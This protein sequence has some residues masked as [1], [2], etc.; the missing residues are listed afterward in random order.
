[1]KTKDYPMEPEVQKLRLE[2]VQGPGIYDYSRLKTISTSKDKVEIGCLKCGTW[3]LVRWSSLMVGHGCQKCKNIEKGLR[4]RLP[5]EEI[6]KRIED[7][8]PGV[9]NLNS[10]ERKDSLL[11]LECKKHGGGWYPI[12]S[13]L[14]GHNGC[15]GCTGGKKIKST[16][17]EF[18]QKSKNK[19]GEQFD[20]S[21]VH[22]INNKIPVNLI[23][24]THNHFFSINPLE[25]LQRN[26]GGCTFCAVNRGLTNEEF[27]QRSK[28]RFPGQLDYSKTKYLNYSDK[29][30]M[31][32]LKEGHGDFE[33]IPRNHLNNKKGG[34]G[35]KI[36]GI[37]NR[38]KKKTYSD[39]KWKLIIEGVHDNK[40]DYSNLHRDPLNKKKIIIECK[41]HGEFSQYY[42]SLSNLN[43]S[44]CPKCSITS[45]SIGEQEVFTF[46]QQYFPL[47]ESR[48]KS[49]LNG[50]E[51]DIYIPEKNI[52]IEYNGLYSHS[53]KRGRD[54]QY[55]LSKTKSCKEKGIILIHLF[56]DEWIERKEIVKTLLLNKLGVQQGIK[57]SARNLEIKETKFK[58][59]ENFLN[60]YHIQKGNI[61]PTT[62][63]GLYFKEELVAVMCFIKNKNEVI[64][65]RYCTSGLIRGGFTK[66][67]KYYINNYNCSVI[68]SFSD[69]RYSE[70]DVYML[71]GFTLEK[72]LPPDYFWCKQQKREHK[73][74]F[75]HKHLKNRLKIYDEN[76]SESE[77]CLNN[78]FFKVWDC[79]KK[80]WRLEIKNPGF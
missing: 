19:F 22:Y 12:Q 35:C 30:I 37:S 18:I 38:I 77:N 66:L 79:G 34:T 29:V 55:H 9:F 15:I 49:I 14:E 1:M 41:K 71:S 74:N 17:E 63:L 33:T 76:L 27:I 56:E 23:C 32:C 28:D 57:Y 26:N 39:E 5:N 7:F 59:A 54:N 2:S 43:G 52:A 40:Y 80:I 13:V 4:R 69:N 68:R 36:C 48:N 11:Y 47:S 60:K 44:T 8:F 31:T 25:H 42:D 70:G 16:T 51:L 73:F 65:S 62:S 6:K 53:E 20:Y 46:I 10:F 24:L 45:T 3:R 50:K 64:L 78:G 67:L 75:R 21:Q 61:F 58:E 72:E